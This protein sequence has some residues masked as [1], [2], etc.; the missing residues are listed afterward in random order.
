M[1]LPLV[2]AA[3]LAAAGDPPD[4]TALAATDPPIVEAAKN[5]DEAMLGRSFRSQLYVEHG[6]T[7]VYANRRSPLKSPF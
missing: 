7:R 5:G 4:V 6:V 1:T 3:A 2:L